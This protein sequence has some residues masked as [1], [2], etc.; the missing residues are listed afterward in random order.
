MALCVVSV[1]AS[2]DKGASASELLRRT[3]MLIATVTSA[4]YFAQI[5]QAL[6]PS[7]AP[8]GA[9]WASADRGALA[10][11]KLQTLKSEL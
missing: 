2:A 10:A 1:W 8:A 11:M 4:G 7:M 3:A 6:N 5:V 9:V